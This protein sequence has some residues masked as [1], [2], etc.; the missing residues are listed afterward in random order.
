MTNSTPTPANDAAP[1][2]KPR[3]KLKNVGIRAASAVG[4]TLICLAPFYFGG[5][6]WA[7][8]IVLFG[9]R[10][11]YEWVRMSTPD[12]KLVAYL[13]PI[14][15]LLITTIYAVQGHGWL[16]A[17]AAL[18]TAA[19]ASAWQIVQSG[20]DRDARDDR[21]GWAALGVIYIIIPCI[22]IMLLRGSEVGF[23]ATGFQQLIF[24]I[25]CVVAA[26]VG[27]FFGGST[28]GGPKLSPRLSPNKTWSG[29]VSGVIA[30]ICV[31]AIAGWVIGLNVWAAAGLAMMI[32]LLSVIGDLIE[33]GFKRTLGVKDTGGLMPGHGGL[34][35][36]M[37]SLMAAVVGA[38][39][40][41][42]VVPGIWPV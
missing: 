22:L 34:L 3:S 7:A 39:I 17:V 13:I 26:D 18:V 12:P 32:A 28:I 6:L 29:F 11:L 23:G 14:I 21:M 1:A 35:D 8:L 27:A 24:I 10:M 42:A 37:D 16:A 15:G 33:S 9:G 5:W 30:A 25:L 36:R 20:G 41:L 40:V 4:L 19:A 31:G 38:A 2:S